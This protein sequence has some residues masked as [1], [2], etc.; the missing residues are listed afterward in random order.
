MLVGAGANIDAGRAGGWEPLVALL[1][2]QHQKTALVLVA[3]GA[4]CA[5]ACGAA[6]GY[7]RPMLAVLARPRAVRAQ[8]RHRVGHV[9]QRAQAQRPR[10]VATSEQQ[11]RAELA[12]LGELEHERRRRLAH[13]ELR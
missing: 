13:G 5:E 4:D 12:A 8:V 7:A 10:H 2:S 9:A 3:A 11:Q 6:N 1:Y